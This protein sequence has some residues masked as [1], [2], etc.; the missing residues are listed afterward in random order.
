MCLNNEGNG[1]GQLDPSPSP[2]AP[3]LSHAA[4]EEGG[5][6]VPSWPLP[7]LHSHA[8]GEEGGHYVPSWPLPPHP[9]PALRER[10]WG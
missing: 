3:F 2:L 4:G 8:A 7:L 10:G 1:G 9:S 5:D 6:Y